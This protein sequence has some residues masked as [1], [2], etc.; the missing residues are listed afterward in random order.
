MAK[1]YTFPAIRSK[2]IVPKLAYEQKY[3]HHVNLELCP[4]VRLLLCMDC[5]LWLDPFDVLV[6]YSG[7]ALMLAEELK[8]MRQARDELQ[9]SLPE[10]HRRERNAKSRLR[11]VTRELNMQG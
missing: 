5:D 1:N 11:R 2:L 4:D 7:K 10:L 9:K 3:C 6:K 8:A